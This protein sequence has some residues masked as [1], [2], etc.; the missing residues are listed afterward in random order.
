MKTGYEESGRRPGYVGPPR[1]DGLRTTIRGTTV[2]PAL[3]LFLWF[4]SVV[5]CTTPKSRAASGSSADARVAARC[6]AASDEGRSWNL[7]NDWLAEAV[8]PVAESCRKMK[9]EGA[10]SAFTAYLELSKAGMP[11][12]AV[13]DPSTPFSRCFGEGSKRIV[14]PNVPR[15]GF[16][17]ELEMTTT[18]GHS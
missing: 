4:G 5:S 17:F 10:D 3:L 8:R 9:L 7:D 18:S 16:W 11:R 12:E 13:V 15:E 14:F 2:A 6:D 1:D